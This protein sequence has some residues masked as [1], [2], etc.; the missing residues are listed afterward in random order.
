MAATLTC[1]SSDS[2][3]VSPQSRA[4]GWTGSS[5]L[6]ASAGCRTCVGPPLKSKVHDSGKLS[7]TWYFGIFDGFMAS[8][9]SGKLS[10]WQVF[11]HVVRWVTGEVSQAIR[12]LALP[13]QQLA[14][15]LAC[16]WVT[17]AAVGVSSWRNVA[18]TGHLLRVDA[19]IRPCGLVNQ[20]F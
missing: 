5:C 20:D 14:L 13:L 7:P 2:G 3:F 12:P 8:V 1:A 9:P 10:Q 17:L 6:H 15:P 11:V 16:C 18:M 4:S 19:D